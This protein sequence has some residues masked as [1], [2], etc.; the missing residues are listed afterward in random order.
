LPHVAEEH[1]HFIG[2]AA[3]GGA[4]EILLNRTIRANCQTLAHRMEYI[5][6]ASRP[7]FQDIFADSLMF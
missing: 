4:L 3:G 6:L 7:D 2:N 5:E 1:I